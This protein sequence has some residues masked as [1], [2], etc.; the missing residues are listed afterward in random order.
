M[1][2]GGWYSRY[3]DETTATHP[4]A[5]CPVQHVTQHGWTG[6]IT[7]GPTVFVP[8][9]SVVRVRWNNGGEC[10]INLAHLRAWAS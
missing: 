9:V 10:K 1:T 3:M 5:G 4:L 2:L 6:I 7:D 8:G